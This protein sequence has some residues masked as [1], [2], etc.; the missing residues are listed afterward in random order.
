MS[1]RVDLAAEGET[2]FVETG[3]VEEG[4]PWNGCAAEDGVECCCLGVGGDFLVVESRFG[5]C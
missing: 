5:E 3:D 4:V 2:R 1:Y